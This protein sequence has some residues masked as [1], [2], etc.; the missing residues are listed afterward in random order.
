MDL[1]QQRHLHLPQLRGDP[2][3]I[4]G[5]GQLRPISRDGQHLG[6]AELDAALRWKSA[7]LP[8]PAALQP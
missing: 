1:G 4:R 2:S 5:P 7:V 6:G 3:R 8:V